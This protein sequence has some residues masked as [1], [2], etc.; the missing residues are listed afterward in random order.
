MT[1][2]SL[3]GKY[4]KLEKSIL[5]MKKNFNA[6]VADVI[7]KLKKINL[8]KLIDSNFR[9]LLKFVMPAAETEEEKENSKGTEHNQ[10]QFEFPENEEN[11]ARKKKREVIFEMALF[12]ILGILLGITIKTEAA[13]RITIGF[14]DYTIVNGRNSYN[15]S[16]MKNKL[17][18]EIKEAQSQEVQQQDQQQ[19]AQPQQ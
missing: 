7:D 9:S 11:L 2:N 3:I 19:S 6:A 4:E 13:K 12:L 8:I 17:K 14:N 16:D 15:I 10:A 1:S 18:E 5:R